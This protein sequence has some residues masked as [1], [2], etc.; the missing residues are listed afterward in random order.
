MLCQTPFEVIL[1]I[2]SSCTK[3]VVAS[4]KERYVGSV[5]LWSPFS[6]SSSRF[7][8]EE[9]ESSTR[10]HKLSSDGRREDDEMPIMPK[11]RTNLTSGHSSL[12]VCLSICLQYLSVCEK[13]QT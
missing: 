4:R 11:K 7:L 10:S 2:A 6:D 12:S 3:S 5:A 8:P 9:L 13:G 1:H